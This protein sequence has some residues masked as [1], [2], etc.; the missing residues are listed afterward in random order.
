MAEFRHLIEYIGVLH[1]ALLEMRFIHLCTFE[2]M[3]QNM[4]MWHNTCACGHMCM[5]HNTCACGTTHVHVAQHMCMWHKTCA[6]SN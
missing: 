5:W 1:A 6:Y 2:H 4:C 3:A